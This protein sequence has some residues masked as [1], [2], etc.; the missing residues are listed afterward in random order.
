MQIE[1]LCL[2]HGGRF[3][4]ASVI[5]TSSDPVFLNGCAAMV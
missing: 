3:K 1:F 4:T 5:E 2:R